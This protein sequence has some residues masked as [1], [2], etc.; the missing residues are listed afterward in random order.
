MYVL[1]LSK[2]IISFMKLFSQVLTYKQTNKEYTVFQK[3]L[4]THTH[5]D[6]HRHKH[7]HTHT[8]THT[9]IY[10]YIIVFFSIF[11]FLFS[12][13]PLSTAGT[14]LEH[15]PKSLIRN[16]TGRCKISCLDSAAEKKKIKN[17]SSNCLNR[18]LFIG[19]MKY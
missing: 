9:Y 10:I 15:R 12:L 5:R 2:K 11:I 3:C 14:N 7:R 18:H 1:Q 13:F 4:H 6:A 16:N 19:F 8:H 17:K